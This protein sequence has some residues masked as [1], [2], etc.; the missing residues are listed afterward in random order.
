MVVA[1]ADP[2]NDCSLS[3]LQKIILFHIEKNLNFKF[4]NRIYFRMFRIIVNAMSTI[5]FGQH[6][7]RIIC[8][9]NARFTFGHFSITNTTGIFIGTSSNTIV[10]IES[11]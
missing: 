8:R 6:H 9:G 4:K 7:E 11:R 1:E 5:R 2:P 10:C 3:V